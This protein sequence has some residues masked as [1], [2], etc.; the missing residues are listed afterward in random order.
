MDTLSQDAM[1][2]YDLALTTTSVG[3]MLYFRCDQFIGPSLREYGEWCENE[4]LFIDH[5]LQGRSGTVFDIGANVGYQ[6]LW[7]SKRNWSRIVHSFEC[8][9]QTF[10]VLTMNA[11][12][13]GNGKLMPTLAAIAEPEAH[14]PFLRFAPHAPMQLANLG[15]VSITDCAQD[16]AFTP[17][18]ALDDFGTTIEDRIVLIKIDAEGAEASILRSALGTIRKHLPVLYFELS[19]CCDQC[20]Q[21]LSN[22]GYKVIKMRFNAFRHDNFRAN[23]KDMWDG[24]G[25]SLMGVA[26]HESDHSTLERAMA[27][28]V[29]FASKLL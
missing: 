22:E 13:N 11:V 21:I 7:Y 23:P 26:I 1:A 2:R 5:V 24:N 10:A 27:G 6:G 3:E 4:N 28:S 19:E 8:H 15:N 14:V 12:A 29:N 16:G 25:Y 9:F 20:V 17:V 18:V